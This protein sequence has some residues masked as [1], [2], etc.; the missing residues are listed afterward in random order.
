MLSVLGS[1]SHTG[2]LLAG[3]PDAPSCNGWGTVIHSIFFSVHL[4][5][6]NTHCIGLSLKE[7]VFQLK[8]LIKTQNLKMAV[9]EV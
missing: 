7:S 4:K 1:V 5:S 9:K 2:V 3:R 6:H 8:T